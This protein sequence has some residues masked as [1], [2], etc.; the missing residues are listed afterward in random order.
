MVS[1]TQ[2]PLF[3]ASKNYQQAPILAL[4]TDLMTSVGSAVFGAGGDVDSGR[5]LA[6]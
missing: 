3:L 2:L 4:Y 1:R 5:K 6:L